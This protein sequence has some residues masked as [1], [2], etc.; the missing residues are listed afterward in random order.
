MQYSR[1]NQTTKYITH[2]NTITTHHET[3]LQQETAR[4]GTKDRVTWNTLQHY[5]EWRITI[6]YST[7]TRTQGMKHHTGTI[8]S[9]EVRFNIADAEVA[10]VTDDPDS[11][12]TA[13]GHEASEETQR[14]TYFLW[15]IPSVW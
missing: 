6:P 2:C 1:R 7:M 15:K 5:T 8:E 11:E 9:P 3:Y 12:D 4:H 10:Y 13:G 14:F